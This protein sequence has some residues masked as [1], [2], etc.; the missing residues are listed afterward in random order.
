[1]SNIWQFV[2]DH[3]AEFLMSI[4]AFLQVELLRKQYRLS[5]YLI[6]R[7]LKVTEEILDKNMKRSRPRWFS[8]CRKRR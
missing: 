8:W 2:G 5:H 7:E 3:L 1:M 6:A 4:V